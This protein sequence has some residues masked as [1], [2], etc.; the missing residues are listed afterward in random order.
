MPTKF[1]FTPE[2]IRRVKK[3]ADGLFELL[4]ELGF[5]EFIVTILQMCEALNV[6]VDYTEPVDFEQQAI[7]L[8]KLLGY[9]LF[10]GEIIKLEQ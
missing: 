6:Q 4:P 5:M 1:N 2:Q 8:L 3:A 7:D 9:S 10:D